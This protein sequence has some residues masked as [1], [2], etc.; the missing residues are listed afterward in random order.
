MS[1][2]RDLLIWDLG[3]RCQLDI[4]AEKSY[5]E[6]ARPVW[7]SGVKLWSLVT[8]ARDGI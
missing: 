8:A 2:M 4:Q 5:Q 7:S 3:L 6:E 1:G